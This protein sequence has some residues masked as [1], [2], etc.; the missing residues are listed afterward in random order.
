M[1]TPR[2]AGHPFFSIVIA[3]HNAAAHLE[4]CLASIRA[5]DFTSREI[6]VADGASTDGTLELIARHAAEIASWRSRK[7]TG[8]FDAW[9]EAL[10]RARGEWIMFLG[11]DDRLASGDTLGR[12]HAAVRG[13]MHHRF[14]YGRV[15]LISEAT[16]AVCG[17]EN[18]PW[19]EMK[20]KF[21]RAANLVHTGSINHRSLF[22]DFGAFDTSFRICGDYEFMLRVLL[23][24]DPLFLD[25]M[26]VRMRRGGLSSNLKNVRRGLEE[27]IRAKAMNGLSSDNGGIRLRLAL[28]PCHGLFG[29]VF[30]EQAGRALAD[31]WRR[32][33]G[34]S[35]LWTR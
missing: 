25:M 35:P 9:N 5:Q 18:G 11:A 28:L 24:E 16:G 21:M 6:I 7:D 22:E 4:G 32:L 1:V 10:A 8:P 15:D 33:Q 29:R 27:I 30:G 19:P 12:I 31:L 23:K 2:D 3:T 17:T 14:V 20:P 13:E 34:K 26:V